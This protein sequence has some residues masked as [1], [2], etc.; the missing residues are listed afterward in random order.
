TYKL[1][2]NQVEIESLVREDLFPGWPDA[3]ISG[4]IGL[5]M[6]SD[7]ERRIVSDLHFAH[8]NYSDLKFDNISI[9]GH[10]ELDDSGN[11]SMDMDARLDS[12]KIY[13][14]GLKTEGGERQ[15]HS[16]ISQIPINLIQPFTKE[17][18]SELRG[19]ISGEFDVSNATG[20]DRVD[21]QLSFHGVR[22]RINPLNSS[23]FIPDQ[24]LFV[25]DEK[26]LFKQFRI[27]DTLRNEL[28]V[29]G[30]LDFQDVDHV[31][32][33]LNVS[34]SNLQVMSRGSEDENIPFSGDVF[35]D[36][37]FS[38]KGPLLN[39]SIHGNILLSRG[40]EVFYRHMEDLSM[41]E[42]QKIM[43]FESNTAPAVPL[44]SP[45]INRQGTLIKSS[46]ETIVEI[47]PSTRINVNLSKKIYDLELQIIGGGRLNYNM[48]NNSQMSLS[49]SYEIG[50]GAAELKLVGWPNKSFRIEEGGYIRW[51][52]RVEDP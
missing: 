6:L 33:D 47:D 17:I 38:V 32:T 37:E 49:G 41:T 14:K 28:L 42:S 5:S 20:S 9:K 8:V 7:S 24:G 22:L 3:S 2:M 18:L 1:D 52:G 19:F 11:Y 23:F 10:L 26:I 40:T 12:A 31:S 39:P 48:L 50:E 29:D 35:V 25:A 30:F 46:M 15:I 36:S 34:S 43:S 21:G 51:D 44:A 27:L 13:L 16:K 45:V 4:S